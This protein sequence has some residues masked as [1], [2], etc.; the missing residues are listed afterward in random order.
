M[1]L[2]SNSIGY[3][4]VWDYVVISVVMDGTIG[5]RICKPEKNLVFFRLKNPGPHRCLYPSKLECLPIV[6]SIIT[7]VSV[8]LGII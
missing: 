3:S 8:R 4:S 6:P 7:V 1:M 5:T 2:L